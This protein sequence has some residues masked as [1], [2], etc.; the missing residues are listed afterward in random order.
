[1]LILLLRFY[2]LSIRKYKYVK[3]ERVCGSPEYIIIV[4]HVCHL[5]FNKEGNGGSGPA[6]DRLVLFHDTRSGTVV[7]FVVLV[8][9]PPESSRRIV[10]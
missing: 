8:G 3:C 2:R 1:M 4:T 7:C 9:Y 5:N 10:R 6:L